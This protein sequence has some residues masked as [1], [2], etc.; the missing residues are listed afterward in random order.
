MALLEAVFLVVPLPAWASNIGKRLVKAPKLYLNDTGLLCH[1]LGLN[2]EA[3]RADCNKLGPILENF[4][5]MELIKQAGWSTR[6]PRLYHFRTQTGQEVDL[7][8]ETAGGN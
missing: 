6:A 1:L 7:V 5:I 3:L 4:V 8:L 2:E